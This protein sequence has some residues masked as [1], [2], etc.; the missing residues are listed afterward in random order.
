MD[1]VIPLH[2]NEPTGTVREALGILQTVA[3]TLCA[4]QKSY[5]D[6]L[7][8]FANIACM[9]NL[10]GFRVNGD[11]ITKSHVAL[12]MIAL[13]LCRQ[14]EK[15]SPD[16]WVDIAGYASLAAAMETAMRMEHT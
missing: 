10:L 2:P 12:A 11:M 16:N 5:G 8:C 7:D 9:W 1:K 4:R 3:E 14:R 13:K 6:P 15:S